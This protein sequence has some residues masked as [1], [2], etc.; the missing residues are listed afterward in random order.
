MQLAERGGLALGEAV[1]CQAGW[2]RALVVAP[3]V[4]AGIR[5]GAGGAVALTAFGQF[6]VYVG[7]PCAR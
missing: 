3:W 2:G 4:T 6:G 7:H 5:V 1:L